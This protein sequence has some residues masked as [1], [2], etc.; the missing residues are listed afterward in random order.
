MYT[1]HRP[2]RGWK[3]LRL[4]IPS[5]AGY[6]VFV[7]ADGSIEVVGAFGPA[8]MPHQ[9]EATGWNSMIIGLTVRA[10]PSAMSTGRSLVEPIVSIFA[11]I[12]NRRT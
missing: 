4:L 12:F 2:R 5:Q 1:V 11:V 3:L 7:A 8:A 9:G 6:G 10:I